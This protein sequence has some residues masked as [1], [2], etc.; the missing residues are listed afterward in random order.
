[1]RTYL[2][3]KQ[4]YGIYRGNIVS[5]LIA[6]DEVREPLYAIVPVSNCWRWKSRWKHTQRAIK[7][8]MDSGAVVI[9]VEVAFNRREFVFADSGIDGMAANCAIQ[10]KEFQHK[11]IGLR[12]STELWLKENA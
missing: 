11:F 6:K 4:L 7:H 3:Y 5:V 1:M 9:L 12:S 2:C 10:G 8:F